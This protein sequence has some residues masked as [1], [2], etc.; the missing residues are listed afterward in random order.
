MGKPGAVFLPDYGGWRPWHDGDSPRYGNADL[1]GTRCS[2]SRINPCKN[3]VHPAICTGHGDRTLQ[4][5]PVFIRVN[6]MMTGVWGGIFMINFIL[7]YLAFVYPHSAGGITPPLTYLVLI[8]GIIFTIS[9]RD[10][11]RKNMFIHASRTAGKNEPLRHAYPQTRYPS[12]YFPDPGSPLTARQFANTVYTM[13]WEWREKCEGKKGHARVVCRDIP[14]YLLITAV[15]ARDTA[16][17]SFL[18]QRF[19][20]ARPCPWC[21]QETWFQERLTGR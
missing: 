15:A 9:Y 4:E 12:V 5:N 11:C 1:C 20:R 7:D 3:S 6:I 14:T 21:P 17:L 19:L 8:V 16:A 13:D 18:L 2:H 10:I